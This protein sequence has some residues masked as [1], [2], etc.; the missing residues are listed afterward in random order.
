[1][2]Q[3]YGN[4]AAASGHENG[5]KLLGAAAKDMTPDSIEEAQR[6]A[7]VCMA[8]YYKDCD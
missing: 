5:S 2:L 4:I 7:R 1:L 3:Y 8:S 6:R